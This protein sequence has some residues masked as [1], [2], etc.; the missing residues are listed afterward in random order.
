MNHESVVQERE[1]DPPE[2]ISHDRANAVGSEGGVRW[3][4][5]WFQSFGRSGRNAARASPTSD[6]IGTA[7]A[8]CS[9]ATWFYVYFMSIATVLGT[10]VLGLP[11][12][13]Y[14]CGIAPFL[15]FFTVT[16]VA[17][18]CAVVVAVELLQRTQASL[19]LERRT[20]TDH[21][22]DGF[23]RYHGTQYRAG[24]S[25]ENDHMRPS[26]TIPKHRLEHD[27]MEYYDTTEETRSRST[28]TVS[29]ELSA[30]RRASPTDQTILT[31]SPAVERN[32]AYPPYATVRALEPDRTGALVSS[33]NRSEEAADTAPCNR[34]TQHTTPSLSAM[35]LAFLQKRWLRLLFQAAVCLHF[36]SIMISYGLAG[37]Q[38]YV[39]LFRP[40]LRRLSKQTLMNAFIAPRWSIALFCAVG[41]ALL[42]FCL[43]AVLP[44]LTIATG[45]KATL[46]VVIVL[47]VGVFGAEIAN[48]WRNQWSAFLE[49]FLMGTVALGGLTTV[50]PVTYARLGEQPSASGVR[51]YRAAVIAGLITC[52]F[53]NI[54]WC[55]SVLAVVPQAT[56]DAPSQGSEGVVV[57]LEAANALGEI[58]T[59]PLIAALEQHRAQ[60]APAV[61]VLVNIFITVSITVSFLVIGSGLRHMIDGVVASWARMP[62]AFH[63]TAEQGAKN[64]T[65]NEDGVLESQTLSTFAG[66]GPAAVAGVRFVSEKPAR[67]SEETTSVGAHLPSQHGKSWEHD[68]FPVESGDG[69]QGQWGSSTVPHSS[70]PLDRVVDNMVDGSVS[71]SAGIASNGQRTRPGAKTLRYALYVLFYGFIALVAVMN[72]RGFLAVME[73]FA[74]LGLNLACGFFIALMLFFARNQPQR[75]IPAPLDPSLLQWICFLC[76]GFFGLASALDAAWWLPRRLLAALF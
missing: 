21:A 58:S 25:P 49:P 36:I 75:N 24:G 51:R 62:G 27:R 38:A 17:E 76:F 31:L 72:P 41:T 67:V 23:R 45:I 74:S 44:V 2:Q 68:S 52:Y 55:V 20:H 46:L 6:F 18:A 47:V 53:L 39:A 4:P 22:Q 66:D 71:S 61:A 60:A 8:N 50:M 11:V 73:G 54:V 40:S 19:A 56:P 70:A 3:L 10:G 37:P 9:A 32:A 34:D 65:L 35:A 13:L 33:P 63:Q 57:S 30:A 12:S 48:P 16:V 7:D 14:R 42:I 15:V 5:T 1:C 64:Q 29:Q 28:S 69:D 26:S 59:V 43:G